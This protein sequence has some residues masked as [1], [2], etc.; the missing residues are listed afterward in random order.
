[1]AWRRLTKAQWAAIRIQLPQPKASPRGGRPRVEDRRC[2]EGIL[3]MLWTGAQWSALPRRYGSPSTCWRRLKHWEETGVLLK[4]W[5]AFLAQLND[6]EKLRWDEGF[7]DGS[8]VP[9]KRGAPKSV[10]PSGA[11]GHSGWVWLMARVLRWEQ[12]WTRRP[13]RKSP[14]SRTRSPRSR[15]GARARQDAPATGPSA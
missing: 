3:W 9:A 4:L 2:F 7:A 10:K 1:M 12:T 6:Q 8:C 15:S 5:R 13:Q 14:A 11:R